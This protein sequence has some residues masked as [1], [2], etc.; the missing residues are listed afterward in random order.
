MSTILCSLLF[1]FAVDHDEFDG[2]GAEVDGLA[3]DDVFCDAVEGVGFSS[4]A[5]EEEVVDGDFEGGA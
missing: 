4:L 2:A 5:G 3:D 1:W